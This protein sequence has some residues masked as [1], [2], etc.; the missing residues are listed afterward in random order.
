MHNRNET[1]GRYVKQSKPAT[2]RQTLCDSTCMRRLPW[3]DSESGCGMVA[4]RGEKREKWGVVW[5][6][7]LP[8]LQD[9]KVLEIHCTAM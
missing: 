9:E 6:C 7:K 3:S 4:V 1:G 2:E 5:G 8:V